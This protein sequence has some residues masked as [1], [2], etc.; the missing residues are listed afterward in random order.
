MVKWAKEQ[1][2]QHSEEKQGDAGKNRDTAFP[3]KTKTGKGEG[4]ITKVILYILYYYQIP[5]HSPVS[6]PSA[7]KMKASVTQRPK[8]TSFH[9]LTNG[10]QG[11]KGKSKEAPIDGTAMREALRDARVLLRENTEN[12]PPKRA[13]KESTYKEAP[14]EDKPTDISSDEYSISNFSPDHSKRDND[15]D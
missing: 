3:R 14:A 9:K 13:R 15:S 1:F 6:Q 4:R 10:L 12:L 5:N 2:R 7:Y 8:N 11:K